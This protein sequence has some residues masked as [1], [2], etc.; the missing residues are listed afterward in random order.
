MLGM[1]LFHR[2]GARMKQ[3]NERAI[4]DIVLTENLIGSLT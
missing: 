4:T 2:E 3:L 1:S